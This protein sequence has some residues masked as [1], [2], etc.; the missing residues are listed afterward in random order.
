MKTIPIYAKRINLINTI[1]VTN[2]GDHRCLSNFKLV[3]VGIYNRNIV[4]VLISIL[5]LV[6]VSLVFSNQSSERIE[7]HLQRGSNSGF[8]TIFSCTVWYQY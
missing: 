3:V 6:L 4:L 1:I 8:L 2:I 5:Q 7:V